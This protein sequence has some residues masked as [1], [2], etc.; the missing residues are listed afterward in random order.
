MTQTQSPY[1]WIILT[2]ATLT[3]IFAQAAPSI[4]MSV[5]FKEISTD[6]QL[7]LVQIGVVWGISALPSV[8]L[9]L[10]AGALTDRI[11]PKKVLVVSC[12]LTALTSGMRG[13]ATNFYTLLLA[14]VLFG[15]VYPFL[16]M[17]VFKML[18]QWFPSKQLG[19]AN[20]VFSMGMA[21]GF[22]L[23]SAIS[24]SVLS[25]ALGGWRNTLFF[26]A[27]FPALLALGWAFARSAHPSAR[28]DVA[29]PG[30]M[31]ASL[32]HVVRVRQVWAL[33][34]VLFGI[35]GCVQS[36]L[37]YL[38]TYLRGQGWQPV[39]ADNAAGLFHLAS[40]ICVLPI[41]LWTDRADSRRRVLLMVA[42]LMALG[43]AAWSFASGAAMYAV[44]AL[45]G[46]PRDGFMGGFMPMIPEIRQIGTK[47]V[48]TATGLV[49]GMA[50]L[51]NFIAPPIGNSLT[52]IA[53]GAPFLFWAA[54]G[55]A[56]LVI[57][58]LAGEKPEKTSRVEL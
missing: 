25:P 38:P 20:G 19:M 17:S 1:R 23:G 49:T 13:A 53:P 55:V 33:A 7:D 37:G 4:C 36:A 30:A 28:A 52:A 3:A 24:A 6:L 42:P 56:G 27:A 10:V 46:L 47:Y 29:Q 15:S 9:G 32:A 14:V 39:S 57:L 48:A 58:F 41:S 44:I 18:S 11:G 45:A 21:T 12:V 40:L 16:A 26:Y 51:A 50:A 8:V 2:L 35:S 31:R 34:L 54:L 22:M 5:L 43:I